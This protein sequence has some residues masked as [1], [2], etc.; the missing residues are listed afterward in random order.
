MIEGDYIKDL[1]EILP[2]VILYIVTGYAFLIPFHFVA[3]KQFSKDIEHILLLSIVVGYVYCNI[4]YL[5]PISFSDII[6]NV[7]IVIS[8]L[9]LG[10][11]FARIWRNKSISL[12]VF[13]WLKIRD[14]GNLYVWDDIMDDDYPMK[15][16]IYYN[17]TVY[18]GLIHLYESYSK[19]PQIV[20]GSYVI[21]NKKGRIVQD[22]TN[23]DTRI[24]IL[25]ISNAISVDIIYNKESKECTDIRK[26][27]N[28]NKRNIIETDE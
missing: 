26:L 17:N 18:E 11:V 21:K 9:I 25:N 24:T 14:T 5:I 2:Q 10:N 6:D 1:Y 7:L 22:F 15:A 23:D 16:I 13:E 28:Y 19:E 4:A 3:L 8:A 20:L 27:C 12:R